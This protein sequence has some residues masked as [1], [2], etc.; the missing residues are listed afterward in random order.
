MRVL[1]WGG[2]ALLLMLLASLGCG[3]TPAAEKT[4]SELGF[5]SAEFVPRLEATAQRLGLG[6]FAS[7]PEAKVGEKKVAVLARPYL[8][9]AGLLDAQGNVASVAMLMENGPKDDAV[10]RAAEFA[11][12]AN[13]FV[14][15]CEPGL[16][17][18][19]RLSV[20]EGCGLLS[21]KPGVM[22]HGGLRYEFQAESAGGVER[23]K[24][25]AGK[26]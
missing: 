21:G 16:S 14:G 20:L 24:F 8:G 5:P 6:G 11:T 9:F 7:M 26:G 2:F 25:S 18:A 3:G 13:L 1:R 17:A 12:A 23:M 10:A 4:V 15:L 19:E 22:Q